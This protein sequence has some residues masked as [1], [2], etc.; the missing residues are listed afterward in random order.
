MFIILVCVLKRPRTEGGCEK[1][2]PPVVVSFH[3]GELFNSMIV[4]GRVD[5]RAL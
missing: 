5:L 4:G 3:L 2:L 1:C